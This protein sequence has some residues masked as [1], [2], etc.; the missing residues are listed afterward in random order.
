MSRKPHNL[1]TPLRNRW[2][3]P[4]HNDIIKQ[5]E[6]S[7]VTT[8]DIKNLI[9]IILGILWF[10]VLIKLL[11]IDILFGGAFAWLSIFVSWLLKPIVIRMRIKKK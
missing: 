2:C 4:Y 10:I 3:T 1:L 11:T 8:G 5:K 9:K 7:T 6:V